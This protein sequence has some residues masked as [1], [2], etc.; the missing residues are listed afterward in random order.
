[1]IDR[2]V[3]SWLAISAAVTARTQPQARMSPVEESVVL[4]NEARLRHDQT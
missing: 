2:R 1:M 4:L 3:D